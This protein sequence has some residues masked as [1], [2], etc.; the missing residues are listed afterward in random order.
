[1]KN[2]DL[3]ISLSELQTR[4]KRAHQW[5]GFAWLF[6]LQFFVAE[7]IAINY[8]YGN[9][10]LSEN[11]ISDLGAGCPLRAVA[12]CAGWPTLMNVSFMLQAG[13]IGAGAILLGWGVRPL[14][15]RF[16]FAFAG[17]SAPALLLVGLFPED[18]RSALHHDAAA[19]HFLALSLSAFCF[20]F[21]LAR[22][23]PVPRFFVA[24]SLSTAL[25]GTLGTTLLGLNLDFGFG[26]GAVERL[27]AYPFPI[28]LAGLGLAYLQGW[29][30]ASTTKHGRICLL[31]RL[32][33]RR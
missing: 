25:T 33:P 19:L 21:G 23:S 1:M 31:C 30:A 10:T 11:F 7:R 26:H 5:G 8:W 4:N 18:T 9:Y 28:W 15:L 3:A 16:G 27:V 17:L 20:A 6:C 14:S 29:I 24:L 32:V 2:R 22:K 13:L 12:G